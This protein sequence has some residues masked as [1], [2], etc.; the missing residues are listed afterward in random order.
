[1]DEWK[2]NEFMGRYDSN[3][4]IDVYDLIMNNSDVVWL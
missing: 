4:D 2:G 1:M 3:V